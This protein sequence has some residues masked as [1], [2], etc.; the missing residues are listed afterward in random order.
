[1]RMRALL[2]LAGLVLA[3]AIGCSGNATKS[4]DTAPPTQKPTQL[5]PTPPPKPPAG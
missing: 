5:T 1:M 4:K 3:F 2:A